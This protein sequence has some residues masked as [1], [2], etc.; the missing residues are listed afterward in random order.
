MGKISYCIPV[1]LEK[2]TNF[3]FTP[4]MVKSIPKSQVSTLPNELVNLL[5]AFLPGIPRDCKGVEFEECQ[6]D[7]EIEKEKGI[8][9]P[10]KEKNRHNYHQ[11]GKYVY[12]SD[13]SLYDESSESNGDFSHDNIFECD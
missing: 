12:D 6:R 4:Y 8:P 11:E 7:H 2:Y 3:T 5:H 13:F 1:K 10:K 9:I